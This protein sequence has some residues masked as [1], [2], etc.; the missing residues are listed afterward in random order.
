[1]VVKLNLLNLHV[2]LQDLRVLVQLL[3]T[4]MLREVL[5]LDL[6]NMGLELNLCLELALDPEGASGLFNN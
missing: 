1:M 3:F 2:P 4:L 6:R 5:A